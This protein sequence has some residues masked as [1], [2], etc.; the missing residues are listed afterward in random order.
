MTT[1]A[2]FYLH[3][4]FRHA[5]FLGGMKRYLGGYFAVWGCAQWR[6][7]AGLGSVAQKLK[8]F[9]FGIPHF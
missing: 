4:D 8:T 7:V 9:Q 2:V 3:V 1:Q 5:K 6:S